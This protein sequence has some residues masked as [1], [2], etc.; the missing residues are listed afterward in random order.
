MDELNGKTEKRQSEMNRRTFMGSAAIAAFTII[1]SGV[2]AKNSEKSPSDK[3]NVA[4]IGAGGMGNANVN[5]LAGEKIDPAMRE[6]IVALC[7]VDDVQAAKTFKEF[8]KAK[9]YRDFRKM[10][11]KQKDIDAVIIADAGPYPH[12][13]R[14]GSHAAWQ[15]CICTKASDPSCL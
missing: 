5:N 7:D 15:A 12:G 14:Y 10:L 6:N 3:L 2:L 8:P 1:P 9:T 13:G 11:E 4:V